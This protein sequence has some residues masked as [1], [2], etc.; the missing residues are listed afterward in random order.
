MF[1]DGYDTSAYQDLV[2]GPMIKVNKYDYVLI[3]YPAYTPNGLKLV[4]TTI[5]FNEIVAGITFK[6]KPDSKANPPHRTCLNSY[7]TGKYNTLSFGPIFQSQ[8]EEIII[9]YPA[10]TDDGYHTITK[11]FPLKNI[12]EGTTL[13]GC[14]E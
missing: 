14:Q 13:E 6:G 8:Y 1:S 5:P 4:T 9:A 2:I 12:V 10:Y 7:D 3:A 11:R